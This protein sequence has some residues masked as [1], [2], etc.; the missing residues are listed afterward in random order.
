M[1]EQR[2]AALE[3]ALAG[4]GIDYPAATPAAPESAAPVASAPEDEGVAS[5]AAAMPVGGTPSGLPPVPQAPV[6]KGGVG[7]PGPHA[8]VSAPSR[9]SASGPIRA[10]PSAASATPLLWAS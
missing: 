6:R 9:T 1:L 2:V 8:A 10:S 3:A 4:S 5:P 7:E